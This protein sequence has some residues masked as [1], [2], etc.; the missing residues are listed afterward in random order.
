MTKYLHKKN[1]V[2]NLFMVAFFT[3]ILTIMVVG[4]L[5]SKN[6]V[7]KQLSERIFAIGWIAGMNFWILGVIIEGEVHW[8]GGG[9]ILVSRA[10][11]PV[12]FWV[13]VILNFIVFNSAGFLFLLPTIK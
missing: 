3:A 8:W 6:I 9:G 7:E 2:S 12:W 1:R 10:A 13:F 5:G 4:F 11:H